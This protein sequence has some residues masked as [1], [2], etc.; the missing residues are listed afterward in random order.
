VRKGVLLPPSYCDCP[1]TYTVIGFFDIGF[2]N[3]SDPPAK[4][5]GSGFGVGSA[6]GPEAY[7]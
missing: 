7:R 1:T 6:K 3:L 2:F 5:A 4:G